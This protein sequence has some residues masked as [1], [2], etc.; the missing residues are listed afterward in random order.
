MHDC[1]QLGCCG[2]ASADEVIG[3][4]LPAPEVSPRVRDAG[5]LLLSTLAS[6]ALGLMLANAEGRRAR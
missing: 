4:E 5:W 3:A 2:H 1:A 6:I